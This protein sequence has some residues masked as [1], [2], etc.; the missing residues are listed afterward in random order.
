M[1]GGVLSADS[2]MSYYLTALEGFRR[3]PLVGRLLGGEALLSQHSDLLDLLSGL[4][5]LGTA[6]FGAMMF[7]M[8]RGALH[9]VC[10]SPE[11]AQLCVMAISLL[12]T[13]ALGTVCYS[14]DIMAVAALGT[15]LVL[16][17]TRRANPPG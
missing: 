1:E 14:R 6:L 2:R 3:S 7:A 12:A 10:R 9:G 4:G 5:L 15:L 16:E 8:G 17:G 11:R 13:A